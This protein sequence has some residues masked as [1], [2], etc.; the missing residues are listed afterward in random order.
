MFHDVIIHL[1]VAKFFADLNHALN[2]VRLAFAHEVGDG[3]VEDQNFKCGH[4][5][6]F[7]T[8]L[9]Q[10][11]RHDALQRLGQR[12]ADF[13]LLVSGENVNDTIHR[14]RR[15]LRVQC[16]ENQVAGRGRGD[17]QLDG[18][19]IA[20][21]AD[22]DDVRVFAQRPA[23][24]GGKRLRVDAHFAMVHQAAFA[25]VN[26]FNRVFHRDDVVFAVAVRVV[27]DGRERGG[28]AGTGRPGHDDEA[29]MEHRKFFKH[30]RQR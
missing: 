29:A 7:V 14:L 19:Q 22:H 20:Q 16:A 30:R 4:A 27:H 17:G 8:A 28:F 6:F 23:Q 3:G 13:V 2:L 24:R 26:E 18:F 5:A 10:R 12:L 9:E 21:L 15:A 11:L 25:F 1:H